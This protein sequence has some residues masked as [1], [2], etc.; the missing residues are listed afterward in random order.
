MEGRIVNDVP[1][2]LRT[3]I[4]VFGRRNAGK[5]SLV[6]ALA[7]QEVSIVSDRPG[8]TTDPVSKTME[9]LPLGPCVVTDTA[10]LDDTGE[11]GAKRVESALRILDITDIAILAVPCGRDLADDESQV[12]A[13]CRARGIPVVLARM[14][15]DLSKETP[16]GGIPVSSVSGAG[17]EELRSALGA[18]S[19][20]EPP[21][22]LAHDLAG[23]GE[24]VLCVCPIDAAAPKGRLILPQQ[25][26]IRDLVEHGSCPIVARPQEIP[27][28]VAA[29]GADKIRF[30]V[31]DSQA[32]AEVD[33][34]LPKEVPLTSFSILFARLK[35]DLAGLCAGAKALDSLRDGDTVL[36]AEGCTHRR[37]CGD[38]GTEK[39]PRWLKAYTG[40][41]L[42]FV[43]SS[44]NTFPVERSGAKVVLHCGGCMLSRRAFAARAAKSA[45]CGIPMTNY[46]VAIAAMHGIVAD[47]ATAMVVRRR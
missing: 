42:K 3:R 47:P 45:E 22:P 41:D 30:A 7:N 11:L 6:N 23:K 8:T 26:T 32:F 4:S 14:K 5:S 38:I 16:G 10:G 27:D 17:I 25:Q 31:T 36:V 40:K 39:I 46:G 29:V 9:I 35:G 15:S 1:V 33:R 21:N 13:K 18:L 37:Q 28:V 2:A 44:G 20:D 12:A 19:P 43:F 34:L 24:I